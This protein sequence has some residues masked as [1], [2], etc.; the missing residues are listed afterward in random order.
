VTVV[1]FRCYADVR[2]IK[3][4]LLKF[5]NLKDYIELGPSIQAIDCKGFQAQRKEI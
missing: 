3:N 2:F 4:Q 1:K 5:V